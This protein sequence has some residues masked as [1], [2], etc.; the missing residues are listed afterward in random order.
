ME[1]GLKGVYP[2]PFNNRFTATFDIPNTGL[3]TAGIFDLN[4]REVL[5]V[6]NQSLQAGNHQIG[7]SGETLAS[8]VYVFRVQNAG[9]VSQMKIALVK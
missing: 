5:K 1:F 4:G 2:N 6:I 3:V 8:G 9:K 7:V